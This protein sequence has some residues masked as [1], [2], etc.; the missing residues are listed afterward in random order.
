[1]MRRRLE[2]QSLDLRTQGDVETFRVSFTAEDPQI[3]Q[4]VTSRLTQLF[5]DENL[6]TRQNQAVTTSNFLKEQL[7]VAKRKLAEQEQRLRAFKARYPTELPEQQGSNV[8]ALADLRMHLQ[9]VRSRLSRAQEQRTAL[10]SSLSNNLERLRSEKAALLA[11]YTERHGEVIKKVAEIASLERW[12]QAMRSGNFSSGRLSRL[13]GP[14][15]AELAAQV[16]ANTRDIAE[17]ST[18]EAQVRSELSSYQSR[19][20]LAP[21]REQELAAIVSDH[22]LFRQQYADLLTKQQQSQLQTN[23]EESREGLQF[24]LVDPPSLP[25][26]P[27]GPKRLKLSL[28]G[29]AA[30]VFVGI[31]LGFLRESRDRSFYCEK[32]LAKSFPLPVVFGVPLLL[33]PNE[34]R[35][36]GWRL[37]SEW[38]A[39]CAVAAAVIAAELYVYLDR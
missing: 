15:L 5:I 13:D 26:K 1:M 31:A 9:S 33:T 3:A 8:V 28:A 27:S 30:G 39:G 23:L 29:L 2:I 14:A 4:A 37:A 35:L 12:L 6:R 17:L 20:S 21:V 18:Q 25:D 11:R 7:E 22:D 10:E 32:A 16:E 19:L 24:R 34:Q 38:V 36:R